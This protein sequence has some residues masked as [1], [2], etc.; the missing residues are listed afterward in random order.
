MSLRDRVRVLFND[1]VF[2]LPFLILPLD[3]LLLATPCGARERV[4]AE[5]W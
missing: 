1:H 2:R 5:V 3:V 4:R